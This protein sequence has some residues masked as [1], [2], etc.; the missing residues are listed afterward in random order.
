MS[1]RSHTFFL[2]ETPDADALAR[3]Q[4]MV[5]NG[6]RCKLI[7]RVFY[8]HAPKGIGRSKLA[9]RVEGILGVSVTARNLRTV[10]NVLALAETAQG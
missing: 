8:L 7:R 1:P 2:D 6:E 3:A 5:A 9:A 4:S 10:E